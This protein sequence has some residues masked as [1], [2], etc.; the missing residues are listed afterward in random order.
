ME[1][2]NKKKDDEA[3][4]ANANPAVVTEPFL[5]SHTGPRQDMTG[6]GAAVHI[7]TGVCVCS[8]LQF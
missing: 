1:R 7:C 3:D 5:L 2:K 6:R 8:E 4:K